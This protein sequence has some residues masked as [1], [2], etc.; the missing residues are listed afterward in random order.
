M[1]KRLVVVRFY[2]DVV[3]DGNDL[4]ESVAILDKLIKVDSIGYG[5][6]RRL[7]ETDEDFDDFA[8]VSE[9]Q[10][11]RA[12]DETIVSHLREQI[13]GLDKELERANS[14]RWQAVNERDEL[15]KKLENIAD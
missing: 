11:I 4:A 13:K 2:G 10:F 5:R 8:L 1:K 14:E 3:I 6:E 12:S 7:V 15:K 9:S